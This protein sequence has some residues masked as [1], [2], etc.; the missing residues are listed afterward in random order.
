MRCLREGWGG[1]TRALR[2]LN[3]RIMMRLNS[4]ALR[5][6]G[7]NLF[8]VFASLLFSFLIVELILRI[9]YP[10]YE[11]AAK[12]SYDRNPSRI[13]SR[14]ANSH[15]RYRHP[16]TRVYYSVYHNNLSLRQHRNFDE[17]DIKSAITVAFFGDSFTENLFLP[18]QYSLTEP[19]DYL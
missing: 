7:L 14:K 1:N 17:S 2:T 15:H 16:D 3:E 11:H 6:V 19:L 9:C 10:K 8:L 13:W 12:S 5:N 18:A 4:V